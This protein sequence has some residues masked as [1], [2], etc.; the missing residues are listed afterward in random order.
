MCVFIFFVFFF[1][2]WGGSEKKRA[3]NQWYGQCIIKFGSA[4]TN[5]VGFGGPFFLGGG[6]GG[7]RGVGEGM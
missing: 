5:T 4:T 6:G 3:Q 2:F 7:G 1:V